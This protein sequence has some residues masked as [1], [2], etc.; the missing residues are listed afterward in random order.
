MEKPS[1]AQIFRV[2]FPIRLKIIVP[3]LVLAILLAIGAS[4]LISRI[5]FDTLEERYRN[6]LIETGKIS[7]E[8]MV[9]EENRILET[10][11]LI[12][13][14]TGIAEV[15]QSGDAE[16][17]RELTFGIVVDKREQAVEILDAQGSLL[18]SMHHRSGGNIEEYD[19]ASAGDQFYATWDFVQKI[20]QNQNDGFG[21][22]YAGLIQADNTHYFYIAGPIF[23]SQRRLA[24]VVLVGKTVDYLANEI[25]EQTLSQITLYD[26][27]G[28]VLSST[29]IEPR[30]LTEDTST[31][32]IGN[33]DSSSVTRNLEEIRD[34]EALNI[35]YS[36]ILGAWEARND[37][38]LGLIGSALPKNFL[39]S[40]NRITR[41]QIGALVGVNLVLIILVG[42]NLASLITRPLLDLVKASIK[43]TKGDLQVQIDPKTDDEVAVLTQSFNEMVN[44]LCESRD[45]LL[46][47]YNSTLEGWSKALELKDK[48]TEGHTLR[49][50][51]MTIE[52]ARLMQIPDEEIVH[53]Q[54]G[55][56][57]HDIGKMGIPDSI[58]T[59][60]GPLDEKEWALMK[61][62]PDM[63]LEMLWPIA[64]LRP[65]LDIPRHH[66]ERWDGNGYPRHLKGEEIPL[67]ARIFA[68][69]DVWDALIS[70]RPYKRPW[71]INQAIQ[72][73]QAQK[74]HHFDP[75]VV[76]LFLEYIPGAIAEPQPPIEHERTQQPA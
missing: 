27:S 7:S 69:V 11:N 49:V 52:I 2:R 22:K 47:A 42:S 60:P 50:T 66:H 64:Y 18:L 67:S 53:I 33:Q 19:F 36:E 17:M 65:A 44:S 56:L 25:R 30:D 15:I 72:E 31:A 48:E 29:F 6:Q 26:F 35:A 71:T 43:V 13:N 46:Q 23:D 1:D 8:W 75:M 5:V 41:L 3:Y 20:L 28:R 16:Q 57:L 10:I 24:G 70:E 58:L 39:I 4:L 14:T 54:R 9:R 21:N 73:I 34:F 12:A 68:V 37:E 38:D 51:N 40:T 76:D 74:G 59:K 63:A 61:K 62:H 32:V 45:Q 55:A